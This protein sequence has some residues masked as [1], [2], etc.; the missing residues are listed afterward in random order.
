MNG[1]LRDTRVVFWRNILKIGRSPL[2]LLLSLMQSMLWLFLFPLSF[3]RIE[4]VSEFRS[5]GY[6]SYL[7]FFTPSALGLTVL[8]VAFQSGW[9]LANDIQQGMLDKFLINPI[10][11][12]SILLGRLLADGVRMLLQGTLVLVVAFVLGA[13]IETNSLGAIL[14]LAVAVLFGVAWAG[15]S[16]FV[17]LRTKNLDTTYMVGALLTFPMLFL[18]TAIMPPGLLPTWLH[19]LVGFNP[20]TS[21]IDFLRETMNFRI[22]WIHL[23]RTL[24]V[25][26]GIGIVTV[27]GTLRALRRVAR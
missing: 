12:A 20:I 14:M 16:N 9:G 10:H 19:H 21:V 25:I 3:R 15:L 8:S 7:M 11:R 26:C 22:E 23:A 5:L 4:Q 24:A 27:G 13:R 18:S 17:A 6:T 1:L 2:A